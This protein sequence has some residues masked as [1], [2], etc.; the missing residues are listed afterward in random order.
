MVREFLVALRSPTWVGGVVRTFVGVALGSTL[1]YILTDMPNAWESRL[2]IALVAGLAFACALAEA[3]YSRRVW[4]SLSTLLSVAAGIPLATV[5]AWV[6]WHTEIHI[7]PVPGLERVCVAASFWIL[8]WLVAASAGWLVT[9]PVRW[10]GYRIR[11]WFT[12]R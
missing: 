2:S 1:T 9:Q 11:Y 10:V 12:P 8:G 5:G 7:S 3:Y 6:G 4:R